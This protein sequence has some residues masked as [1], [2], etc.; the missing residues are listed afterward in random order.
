MRTLK[1]RTGGSVAEGRGHSPLLHC[2]P[3]ALSSKLC[4][5]VF[6]AS[7][8][9]TATCVMPVCVP[10]LGAG[11]G[12]CAH[13]GGCA[14]TDV[15]ALADVC[16]QVV[17]VIILVRVLMLVCVQVV[18]DSEEADMDDRDPEVNGYRPPERMP[19]APLAPNKLSS[20]QRLL[21]LPKD[22]EHT[23]PSSSLP[24]PF[25]RIMFFIHYTSMAREHCSLQLCV[26][27]ALY[28]AKDAWCARNADL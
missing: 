13:A 6:C 4:L 25:L 19:Y 12:V 20:I 17:G 24:E 9:E 1:G 26:S 5:G 27:D 23:H 11:T 18:G 16:A 14:H 2:S 15:R 21:R 28:T 10:I 8:G 7:L 3:P 22:G